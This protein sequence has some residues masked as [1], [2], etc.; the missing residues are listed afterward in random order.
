[1]LN[2][3]DSYAYLFSVSIFG[4][5]NTMSD[6]NLIPHNEEEEFELDIIHHLIMKSPFMTNIGLMK[7][8]MGI[9]LLFFVYGEKKQCNVYTDI[10]FDLLEDVW[11]EIE[12]NTSINFHDLC[13]IGW[14]I[15]YL[16]Q[17]GYVEGN[18]NEI[19][20]EIDNKIQKVFISEF[21]NSTTEYRLTEAL[22]YIGTRK[23]GAFLQKSPLPFGIDFMKDIELRFP[24]FQN[25]FINGEKTNLMQLKELLEIPL[26]RDK[27]AFLNNPIGLNGLSGYILNRI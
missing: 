15:E 24:H 5:K 9:A 2:R 22:N 11:E 7:G 16:V 1:M 12:S 20:E 13:G 10:A 19:C 3:Q 14:A 6:Y 27:D 26:L 25:T 17:H 4:I 21:E 18:T 8:K 23:Q